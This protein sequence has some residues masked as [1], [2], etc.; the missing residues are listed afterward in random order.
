MYLDYNGEK[1]FVYSK[2]PAFIIDVEDEK[3]NGT[4][5]WLNGKITRLSEN[6]FVNIN[7]GRRI[8]QKFYYLNMDS[9]QGICTGINKIV[10]DFPASTRKICAKF[11]YAV[12][13]GE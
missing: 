12:L 3:F 2:L 9:M 6:S 4:A 13:F 5:V 11:G 7:T 8:E 10:I 1:I